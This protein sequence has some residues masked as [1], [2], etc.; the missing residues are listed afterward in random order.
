MRSPKAVPMPVMK[1][2]M[3]V[4]C[5]NITQTGVSEEYPRRQCIRLLQHITANYDNMQAKVSSANLVKTL[6]AAGRF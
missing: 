1:H 6:F 3:A 5:R 4:V 2:V